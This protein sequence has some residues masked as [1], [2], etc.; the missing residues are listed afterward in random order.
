M[1]GGEYDDVFFVFETV[2]CRNV[3]LDCT[4]ALGFVAKL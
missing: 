1:G 2:N 3:I 4:N